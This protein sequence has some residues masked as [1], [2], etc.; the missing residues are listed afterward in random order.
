MS[1]A[2]GPVAGEVLRY[3]VDGVE[4]SSMK[5]AMPHRVTE[6]AGDEFACRYRRQHFAAL[7]L[8]RGTNSH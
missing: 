6:A 4:S 7:H 5:V 2:G 3:P 8:G 1:V